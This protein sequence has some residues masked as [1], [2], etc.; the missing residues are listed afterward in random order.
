MIL[1][2]ATSVS[3]IGYFAKHPSHEPAWR[4]V[5]A[6]ALATI[7]LIVAIVLALANYAT[8]LG[9]GASGPIVWILPGLYLVAVVFG[10]L[11]GLYLRSSRPDVYAGIGLGANASTGRAAVE[12]GPGATPRAWTGVG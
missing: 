6:P 7:G 10:L 4:R 11:W 3:V 5:I 12:V 8:L 9:A 1:I 2:A